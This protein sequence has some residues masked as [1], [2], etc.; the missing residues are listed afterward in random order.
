M[1]TDI[2][3][4]GDKERDIEVGR[5]RRRRSSRREEEGRRGREGGKKGKRMSKKVP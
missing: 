2:E 4:E 5:E 3:M 1:E